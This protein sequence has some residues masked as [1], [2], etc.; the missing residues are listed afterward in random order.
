MQFLHYYSSRPWR[1]TESQA[2]AR[3]S[4]WSWGAPL[5]RAHDDR[6]KFTIDNINPLIQYSPAAAW[7]E[8]SA[9]NDPLASSYSNNGTF[10]LC[11]TQGASATFTFTGTQVYVFG[12]KRDNH[13][14]YSITLD[15]TPTLLTV[16]FPAV[17]GPLFVS[18]VLK[19][20]QH[21][22][23][24]TNEVT[25]PNKPFLDL[26]F[27]TWTTTVPN[28]GQSKTV[29]DT[30]DSFTYQPATAWNIDLS[31]SL[32]T[33][34]SNNNGQYA[35]PSQG[36]F[37][38][39]FGPVGPTISRY[40]VQLDGVAAGIFNA[41]KAAYTPQ[42]PLYRA[43]NLGGGQHTIQLTSQPGPA[44]QVFAI[45][46]VQVSPSST[47]K[48]GGAGSGG[49]T[50]NASANTSATVSGT[51]A[52][53]SKSNTGPI[54]GGVIAGLAVLAILAFLG[55]FLLRRKRRREQ[56]PNQIMLES[57]YP[58]APAPGGY[59]TV[60]ADSRET[61]PSHLADYSMSNS[62]MHLVQPVQYANAHPAQYPGAGAMPEPPSPPL[63]DPYGGIATSDNGRPLP[64][65][66]HGSGVQSQSTQQSD[67][68]AFHT[69]NNDEYMSM[70]DGASSLG[71]SSTMQSSGAAGL[72]AGAHNLRRSKGGPLPL[73]PTANVPLPPG[74]V[75]M[76][77]DSLPPDY[78]QATEPY[79]PSS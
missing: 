57:K 55:F 3:H 65:P 28:G 7:I 18:D 35:K 25:D 62:Q 42:V 16:F 22:V 44:G 75:R 15:N 1:S 21:T 46:F 54:V 50:A 13:G 61:R 11:T 78:T 59:G 23:T 12:A 37:I 77:L 69:V 14:P 30:D 63:T 74:A 26:D 56:D 40:A 32:L 27:I 6:N 76:Y 29:E 66:W 4:H 31:S 51:S 48:G 43:S 67:R 71:R 39:V 20:G 9:S 47:V 10:T 24:L 73:P 64:S 70:S 41:T 58:A 52:G 8:G 68:R 34:F 53:A 33:G 45:D 79:H 38:S 49:A 17:F 36:A 19:Q 2:K 5:A 72:G 60:T